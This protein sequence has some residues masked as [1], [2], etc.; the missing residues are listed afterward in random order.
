[1][2]YNYR[3]VPDG[4]TGGGNLESRE[5]GARIIYGEY[6]S[7]CLYMYIYVCVFVYVYININI[8]IYI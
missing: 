8:Y 5:E 3:Y 1:M 6:I 2:Y 7:I 4:Q